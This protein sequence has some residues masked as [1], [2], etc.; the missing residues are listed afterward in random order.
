MTAI[1]INGFF[2]VAQFSVAYEM[3]VHIASQMSENTKYEIGSATVCGFINITANLIGFLVSLGLTPVLSA[4]GFV[5]SCA[6]LA[7]LLVI[8]EVLML[9]VSK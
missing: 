2:N 6:V 3:P 5:E 7:G 1:V 9:F 8:S 4:G